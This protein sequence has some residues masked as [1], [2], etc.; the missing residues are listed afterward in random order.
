[1]PG[2]TAFPDL[3]LTVTPPG[4]S[5]T[6]YS[7]YMTYA[8]AYQQMGI[9]QNFGRQGDT[10]TITLTDDWQFRAHPQISIPVLSQIAIQ[11]H[12]AGTSLFA[13]VVTNP[14]LIVDGANR[15]EWALQ[16]TDYTYYADNAIVQGTFN[17][18]SVDRIVI[19]LTQ[20]A[21]CGITAAPISQ[22]GYVAP[23]PVLTEVNFNWVTLSS[24]WKT[25]AQLASSS[26][27]YGWYVDDQRRLHFFD[28]S[29]AVSSGVTITTTPTGTGG[30]TT[31]AHVMLGGSMQYDFD[32]TTIRNRIIV[33]GANQTVPTDIH[34]AATDTWKADGTQTSWPLRYTVTNVSRLTLNGTSTSATMVNAGA[35]ASG[36]WTVQQ[37]AIG[38]WFLVAATPPAFGKI[39][40]IWYSYQIPIVAQA[41]DY[42]SQATYNGPNRGVYT[43]YINDTS[44][45]T[46][47]MALSRARRERTEYAFAAERLTVTTGEDFLGWMR[48]GETVRFI[49]SLVP[50]S[51]NG[52]TWGIDDTFLCI[53]NQISWQ[54]NGYRQMNMSAVRI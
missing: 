13:G 54:S 38:Q 51:Q 25:L 46:T 15:N 18:F 22:G 10:A 23:A 35:A 50:D 27:P 9:S 6:D 3:Q 34:K 33:Q 19:A 48:A 20:Q 11:D 17:G 14:T 7:Q 45:T 49:S 53:S 24:A 16:C 44:L 41:N 39:I 30:S 28:S 2:S 32:G 47:S 12:T 29:T 37:N 26:T 42:Q 52:N 4:G 5:P 1:M 31:Q 21:N 8:G 40:R 36:A 43:E